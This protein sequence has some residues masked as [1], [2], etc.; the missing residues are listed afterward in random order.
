M[1]TYNNKKTLF[2]NK[3]PSLKGLTLPHGLQ[4]KKPPQNGGNNQ[5][6]KISDNDSPYLEEN[7]SQFL[8]ILHKDLSEK[9]RKNNKKRNK[10]TTKKSKKIQKNN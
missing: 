8:S 1:N 2:D 5:Y 7:F 10:K 3:H 9:T 6:T 4:V